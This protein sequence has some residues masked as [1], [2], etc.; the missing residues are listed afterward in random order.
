M[1]GIAKII[2]VVSELYDI[3]S[4]EFVTKNSGNKSRRIPFRTLNFLCYE[5]VLKGETSINLKEL[6]S[7]LCCPE[8]LIISSHERTKAIIKKVQPDANCIAALQNLIAE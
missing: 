8:T 7:L 6:S 2:R 1:E 4:V 3:D 5:S